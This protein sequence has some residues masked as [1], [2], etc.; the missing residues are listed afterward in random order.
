[1]KIRALAVMGVVA[2][3]LWGCGTG[4]SSGAQAVETLSCPAG[5][6]VWDFG[7]FR[8]GNSSERLAQFGFNVADGGVR[9]PLTI[10]DATGLQ[11]ARYNERTRQYEGADQNVNV[12]S[13]VSA[14]NGKAECEFWDVWLPD[15][16]G[17]ATVQFRC[18][19][20]QT[21]Q[22]GSISL[23]SGRTSSSVRCPQPQVRELG[24]V[25][26]NCYGRTRRGPTLQC[27]PDLIKPV[28]QKPTRVQ[29]ESVQRLLIDPSRLEDSAYQTFT[30]SMT[31][32]SDATYVVRGSVVGPGRI[33][34]D[35]G[36]EG[37]RQVMTLWLQ[38]KLPVAGTTLTAFRCAVQQVNLSK[39]RATGSTSEATIKFEEKFRIPKACEDGPAFRN[40]ISSSLAANG[41]DEGA[42]AT[43]AADSSITTLMA[44]YDL[45]ATAIVTEP[46]VSLDN[47][48]NP[49][50]VDFF[51]NAATRVHNMRDY[52]GQLAVPV[53]H[54][55]TLA[56]R[57]SKNELNVVV[58]TPP[59][60]L[61]A[62]TE[63]NVRELEYVV[64][65]AGR[66]KGSFDVDLTVAL[67]GTEAPLWGSLLHSPYRY[68]YKPSERVTL[69]GEATRPLSLDSDGTGFYPVVELDA[70]GRPAVD[71]TARIALPSDALLVTFERFVSE[72]GATTS[73]TIPLTSTLRRAIL[74][75]PRY[76]HT[77]GVPRNYV[78]RICP[79]TRVMNHD[80]RIPG[81]Q[82]FGAPTAVHPEGAQQSLKVAR[83]GCADSAVFAIKSENIVTPLPEVEVGDGDVTELA[84]TTSGEERM[85]ATFDNDM[86]RQCV[87]T[88]CDTATQ[89]GLRGSDGPVKNYL[90]GVKSTEEQNNTSLRFA[91]SV[92]LLGFDVLD[93][94]RTGTVG[95]VKT[96]FEISPNW[97]GIADALDRSLP[98]F[99][100]V[101][102]G[103]VASGIV[104]LTM[105][106]EFKVPIRFGP[107]QGDVVFGVS[108]GAGIALELTH[109]YNPSVE[110]TCLGLDG[111]TSGTSCAGTTVLQ[112]S[113][114]FRDAWERCYGSGGILIEPRTDNEAT[115]LRGKIPAATEAWV[116]A[117][118]GNEYKDGTNCAAS[119]SSSVCASGHRQ[120][121]RWLS[122]A[123][124]FYRSVS[125]APFES[126]SAPSQLNGQAV[127]AATPATAAPVPSAVTFTNT[128]FRTRPLTDSYP[129]VC[130]RP[131]VT[132]GDSHT[133]RIGLKTGFKV[134]F[135]VGF[136]VPSAEAGVCL[137]GS[138]NV[139]EATVTPSVAYIHTTVRDNLGASAVR[140]KLRLEVKWGVN[141]LSGDIGVKLVTPIFS[142]G[143]KLIA[144]DGFKLGEGILAASEYPIRSD[145]R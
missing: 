142:I 84:P 98:S 17:T 32:D 36:V 125:F 136:C 54:P 64:N 8:N 122:D 20:S 67:S 49:K 124:S 30:N 80:H 23:V 34:A 25:P 71:T 92:E 6:L 33:A 130:Y 59:S 77:T 58:R 129:S 145:F 108:A 9:N 1:M 74:D 55:T 114:P 87:G 5:Q 103:R 105:G 118:V 72:S 89:E 94:A 100:K 62:A 132:S 15:R 113:L 4:P 11:K 24:C 75:H 31:F 116:G 76:R 70:R 27:E 99:F 109:E 73:F 117:Q 40:A 101:D 61:I 95:P 53:K 102:T 106:V 7:R 29:F 41:L 12:R 46:G 48:C 137:E 134:G 96:T 3:G 18:G 91:T 78:L 51:F 82:W 128:Q 97:Q 37:P 110:S 52:Y 119:W 2:A 126:E 65:R 138:V 14:C 28:E 112:P 81:I 35:G 56:S 45:D 43:L 86:D 63:T 133:A 107:I 22:T 68:D 140:S 120:F 83:N 79:T 50:P 44:S 135:S 42:A 131:R 127:S 19:A 60:T 111:G 93:A 16:M 13:A 144:F 69:N 38:S 85:T 57:F 21:T 39:Y 66:A 88:R 115:L 26:E 141:L 47:T 90:F 121:L 123:S 104:G 139:L 143:Y 10:V